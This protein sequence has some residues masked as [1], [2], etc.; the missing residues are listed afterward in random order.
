MKIMNVDKVKFVARILWLTPELGGRKNDIPLN[1]EMY[2]PQIRFDGLVGSWSLV[3]NSYN[4]VTEYETLADIRYLNEA[5]APNNLVIG[6][7]FSL[8]EGSKKVADGKIIEAQ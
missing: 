3:V 4:K 7:E 8:Y 1:S 2:A 6:L 5:D